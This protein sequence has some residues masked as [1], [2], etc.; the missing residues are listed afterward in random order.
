M[1]FAPNTARTEMSTTGTLTRYDNSLSRPNPLLDNSS[2]SLSFPQL[3]QHPRSP[4]T[5]NAL[6]LLML[7]DLTTS[8]R[9][10]ITLHNLAVL[11]CTRASHKFQAIVIIGT[12]SSHAHT[13]SGSVFVRAIGTH[14][15]AG[16]AITH[17]HLQK[18]K[19]LARV[20]LIT[21]KQGKGGGWRAGKNRAACCCLHSC[22]TAVFCRQGAWSGLVVFSNSMQDHHHPSTMLHMS[23]STHNTKQ[24]TT[25]PAKQPTEQK[26]RTFGHDKV[27][28]VGGWCLNAG[29][30]LVVFNIPCIL[31]ADGLEAPL[32]LVTVEQGVAV[33][34]CDVRACECVWG[35]GC[36]CVHECVYMSVCT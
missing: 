15:N 20:F 5:V 23:H 7:Q 22:S 28:S 8:L 31:P 9:L 27:P 16:V 26:N 29:L 30:V 19:R 17:L 2:G 34:L 24:P 21:Y 1:Y 4:L 18:V 6:Q 3:T 13:G 11:A 25:H 36:V 35:R 10:V 33:L 12:L 14:H 32:L